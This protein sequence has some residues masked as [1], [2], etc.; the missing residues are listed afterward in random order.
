MRERGLGY[1][2]SVDTEREPFLGTWICDRHCGKMKTGRS[3]QID[4]V[5]SS[6]Q[7][8]GVVFAG[9]TV[10]AERCERGCTESPPIGGINPLIED[11]ETGRRRSDPPIQC[12]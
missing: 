7:R 4:C 2:A 6:A 9:R 1:C 12:K 8:G 5:S 11:D 3:E 10:S